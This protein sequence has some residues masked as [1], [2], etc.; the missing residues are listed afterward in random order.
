MP[1]ELIPSPQFLKEAK[2]L[3]K[4]HASLREDLVALGLELVAN[5]TIGEPLG[6]DCYKVRVAITS[7]GKGKSGG[8]RVITCVKI[9]Q[10][11]IFL[12]A[13]YDKSEMENIDDGILKE[14]LKFVKK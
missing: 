1:F 7:K 10:E 14:R 6:K 4:K 3:A 12:L 13:I 9:V 5:P 11:R 2:V 8:A